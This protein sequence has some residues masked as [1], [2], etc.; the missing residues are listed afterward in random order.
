VAL[1]ELFARF[2]IDVDSSKLEKAN[3]GVDALWDKLKSLAPAL[4]G[5]AIGAGLFAFAE[6]ISEIG[7]AIEDNSKRLGISTDA[8]QELGYAAKQT[9]ASVEDLSASFLVLQDKLAGAASGDAEAGKAFRALG[10]GVKDAS[11]KIRD[12]EDVFSDA[13]A[14]IKRMKDPAKQ[15]QAAVD[16]FGRSGRRLLPLLKE[17]ATGVDKLRKRFKELGGGFSEAAVKAS[18]DFGDTMDDLS[19]VML[20]AKGAIA[21]VL[22]P[23]LKSMVEWV[24]KV[25]GAF[26]GWVKNS[27]AIETALGALAIVMGVLAVKTAIVAAPVLAAAAAF[28]VLFLLVESIVTLFQGGESVVGEF[29]DKLFGVGTA[30]EGVKVIK[31]A[32]ADFYQ[33]L[34]ESLPTIREIFGALKWVTEKGFKIVG[35]TVKAAAWVGDQLGEAAGFDAQADA[36]RR[37]AAANPNARSVQE[38]SVMSR[39]SRAVSAQAT[40]WSPVASGGQSLT[41][42]SAPQISMTVNGGDPAEVKRVVRE[43]LDEH[44]AQS[45]DD[46]ASHSEARP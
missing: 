28:A 32:W 5:G 35:G 2:G 18:D 46:L 44:T 6:N 12:T 27:S 16:L 23:V 25:G 20:G 24:I 37:Y 36:D 34:K 10:I 15:T 4:A 8:Y 9:G 30:A 26:L 40:A 43:A 11:G 42:S 13:A 41:Y 17:G 38:A 21:V 3:K 22:L 1:R 14:A 31:Q 33:K 7:S 29:I 39:V 19:T 45:Y